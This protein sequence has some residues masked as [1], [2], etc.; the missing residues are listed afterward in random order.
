MFPWE[1]TNIFKYWIT[2]QGQSQKNDQIQGRELE[3]KQRQDS[4]FQF[5]VEDRRTTLDIMK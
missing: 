5:N 4:N 1:M 2:G 3:Q